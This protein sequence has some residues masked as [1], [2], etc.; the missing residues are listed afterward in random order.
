MWRHVV[1][2]MAMLFLYG[3]NDLESMR[4]TPSTDR[5]LDRVVSGAR[6]GMSF[7]SVTRYGEP[8]EK[9]TDDSGSTYV[10]RLH[11]P[12]GG[13]VQMRVLGSTRHANPDTAARVYEFIFFSSPATAA[14]AASTGV[15]LAN[16]VFGPIGRQ[17]CSGFNSEARSRVWTWELEDGGGVALQIGDGD[18]ESQRPNV[19]SMIVYPHGVFADEVVAGYRPGDC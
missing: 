14:A 9:D 17:G 5:L 11:D 12:I 2:G 16:T 15:E 8:T 3:C 1:G 19:T 4:N 18:A 10:V 13:F 7:D 6:F